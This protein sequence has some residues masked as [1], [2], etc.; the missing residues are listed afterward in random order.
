MPSPGAH[1]QFPPPGKA[2]VL[3]Y[4]SAR[5]GALRE[6]QTTVKE[7]DQVPTERV[8]RGNEAQSWIQRYP[9]APLL[10][11]MGQGIQKGN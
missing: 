1:P 3:G 8:L 11:A 10:L 2:G 4:L 6:S 7:N 9:A 5:T